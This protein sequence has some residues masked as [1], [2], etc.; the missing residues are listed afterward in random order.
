MGTEWNPRK[1]Q[2]LKIRRIRESQTAD[3]VSLISVDIILG[4]IF[5]SRIIGQI[6]RP[7]LPTPSP[8]FR[9]YDL[10]VH[11]GN[12]YQIVNHFSQNVKKGKP[13]ETLKI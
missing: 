12:L 5:I 3:T 8:R 6:Y 2:P 7:Y 13:N 1:F 9:I 10:I 4:E 11:I